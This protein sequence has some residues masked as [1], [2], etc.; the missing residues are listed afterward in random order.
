MYHQLVFQ[1]KSANTAKQNFGK[2]SKTKLENLDFLFVPFCF[3]KTAPMFL[4][5]N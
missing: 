4:R 5:L 3:V 1:Q 2:I